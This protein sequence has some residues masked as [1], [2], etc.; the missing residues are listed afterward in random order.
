MYILR[1]YAFKTKKTPLNDGVHRIYYVLYVR[2]TYTKKTRFQT[3]YPIKATCQNRT[4]GLILT[5]QLALCY[6]VT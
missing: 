6:K 4:G 5:I 2:K 3:P 1:I